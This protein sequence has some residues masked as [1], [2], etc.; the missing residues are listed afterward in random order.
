MTFALLLGA[1]VASFSATIGGRN[2]D[3]ARVVTRT[4]I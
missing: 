1:F 2:R 4:G 3:H